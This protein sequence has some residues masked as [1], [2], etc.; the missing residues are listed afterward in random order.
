MTRIPTRFQL[1]AGGVVTRRRA[2]GTLEVV[3]IA[4]QGGTVWGLPK[5]LVERERRETLE[6]TARREVREETGLEGRVIARLDPIE[7]WYHGEEGG[8]PVR[9]HKKVYFFLME[10]VAGDVAH[11]DWEVDQARWFPLDEAL[12]RASYDTERAILQQAGELLRVQ[13]G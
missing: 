4:T 3:L 5:G 9:Y 12:E 2:D 11:H 13:P 6:E 8:Q 1:S 10:A 7:Y